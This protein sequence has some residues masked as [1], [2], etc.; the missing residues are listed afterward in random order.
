[1]NKT[2]LA[3]VGPT[4][5]GKSALALSLAERFGGEIVSCDSM[6]I[7]RGMDIGTAKPTQEERRRIVHH[8]IDIL[9]P[10][11]PYSAADYGDAAAR[12]AE[13]ILSRGRL[14]IFCG[15]TGLYLSAAL[16]GRHDD[17][18]PSDPAL[19]ASLTE[20]GNTETGRRELYEELLRVDPASASATH[21]N[22]LRRVV[23]ALEIYR[24]TGTPKS[25]LDEKS[26]ERALRFDCLI[27]GI[28]FPERGELYRRIDRRVDEMMAAGLYGEAK[29]LW[30]RG[31]LAP[32]TTAGQAIGYRQFLPCFTGDLTPD[33]A[34]EE[35][36]TATRRYAKRQLTWFRAQPGIVWLNGGSPDLIREASEVVSARL[37]KQN[38]S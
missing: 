14:P 32:G 5:S 8:M 26:R 6:Q 20:R 2:A 38:Q 34:A 7:Y 18:P 31:A 1:M 9:D 27:L 13:E 22:N 21:Q 3:V 23:R 25:V 24:L 11:E 30:E 28:D 16:T 37:A 36:K 12:I 17:A 4:A 29:T 15:G 33:E 35:I 19:R 10:E